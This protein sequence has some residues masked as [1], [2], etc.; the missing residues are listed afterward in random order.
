VAVAAIA[1]RDDGGWWVDEVA[2]RPTPRYLTT[3]HRDT[4]TRFL[5]FPQLRELRDFQTP[6]TVWLDGSRG[7]IRPGP[8]DGDIYV[9]DAVRKLPY[10]SNGVQHSV[11][12]YRHATSGV[13]AMPDREGHFDHIQPVPATA[14]AF[15]CAAIYASIRCT[16]MVW[17]HYLGKKVRWYFDKQYERLEVIPR[18]QSGTAYS[19]PGYLECGHYEQ[20]PLCENYE[21]V[22][23]E[24]GHS[25]IRGVMGHPSHPVSVEARAREEAFA[26]LAAMVALLHFEPMVSHLL[27][28]TRGNLFSLNALSKVGELSRKK[29]VR[30]AFNDSVLST[31]EWDPDPDAFKY[32]LAAPLTGAAFDVLVDMYERALVRRRAIPAAL[33]AA[34]FDYLGRELA[35]IQAE[36]AKHYRAKA[37]LF[38]DALLEARDA[39]AT[40]LARTWERMS[41]YDLYP[42]VART[43]IQVADELGGRALRSIVRESFVF[44][45]INPAV[46]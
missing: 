23:H 17:E 30:R 33:A 4:G 2:T 3:H 24:V 13:R 22:A 26:D 42:H 1:T 32:A 44:R 8:E 25:I 16:L 9:I 11:P 38:E 35:E 15:S 46:G 21:I 19:R 45:D 34:S 20:R 14:R 27:R 37:P 18:I 39:F 6:V 7:P 12:P 43:M 28:R 41:P 40:L 31:V 36:F 5:L 10:Y 29:T